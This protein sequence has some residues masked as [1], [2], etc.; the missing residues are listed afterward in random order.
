MQKLR[1]SLIF[2]WFISSKSKPFSEPSALGIW[3]KSDIPSRQLHN[4]S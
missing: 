4:Q 2:E 3:C 1:G